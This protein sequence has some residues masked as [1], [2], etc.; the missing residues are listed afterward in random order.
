MKRKRHIG[1]LPP[2]TLA[3]LK[4]VMASQKSLESA[5]RHASRVQVPGPRDRPDENMTRCSN[6]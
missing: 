1:K 6:T 5:G 2:G 4:R 3:K